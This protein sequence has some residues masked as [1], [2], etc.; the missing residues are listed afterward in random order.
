MQ[1]TERGEEREREKRDMVISS[2]SKGREIKN[3]VWLRTVL[4]KSLL[5]PCAISTPL[6]VQGQWQFCFLI[7]YL[8]D[9]LVNSEPSSLK[10]PQNIDELWKGDFECIIVP[11][12]FDELDV[13][14]STK[15]P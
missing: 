13:F 2:K 14:D 8:L 7:I 9:P 1:Q 11:F 6:R 4:W 10:W 12:C 3:Q 15:N 5:T